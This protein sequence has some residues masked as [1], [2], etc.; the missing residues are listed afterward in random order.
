MISITLKIGVPQRQ[1]ATKGDERQRLAV[2][3]V[4]RASRGT[5]IN[6]AGLR[7]KNTGALMHLGVLPERSPFTNLCLEPEV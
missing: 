7:L 3:A 5:A 6:R 1:R 4:N 2:S